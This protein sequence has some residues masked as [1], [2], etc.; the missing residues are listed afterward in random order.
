MGR[1]WKMDHASVFLQCHNYFFLTKRFWCRNFDCFKWEVA[2]KITL[3]LAPNV[4]TIT[5]FFTLINLHRISVTVSW[6]RCYLAGKNLTTGRQAAKVSPCK[7]AF[8][9]V[10]LITQCIYD[11]RLKVNWSR[12][13]DCHKMLEEKMIAFRAFCAKSFIVMS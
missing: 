10:V 6:L 8:I 4:S 3:W 9:V 13:V 11:F 7:N 1:C 5:L 12:K 2:S